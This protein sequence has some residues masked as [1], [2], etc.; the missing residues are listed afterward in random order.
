MAGNHYAT[1][2]CR[3]APF[4]QRQESPRGFL[5][6]ERVRA[7]A[8]LEGLSQRNNAERG[9]QEQKVLL[10]HLPLQIEIF[11]VDAGSIQRQTVSENL[12]RVPPKRRPR[13]TDFA[14]AIAVGRA[15]EKSLQGH[16]RG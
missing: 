2:R 11:E 4:H 5:R 16:P 12:R 1:L 7:A 14:G 10:P 13:I 6:S 15:E 9:T 8:G 3:P